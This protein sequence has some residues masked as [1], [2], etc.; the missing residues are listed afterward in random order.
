MNQKEFNQR[1]TMSLLR[2]CAWVWEHCM[3]NQ[4]DG[5]FKFEEVRMGMN[6]NVYDKTPTG[7]IVMYLDW[8]PYWD[9]FDKQDIEGVT[10]DVKSEMARLFILYDRNGDKSLGFGC[11]YRMNDVFNVTHALGVK[12]MLNKAR[13]FQKHGER[14]AILPEVSKPKVKAKKKATTKKAAN[15]TVSLGDAIMAAARAIAA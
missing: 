11:S 13:F 3:R 5:E 8:C 10:Y 14:Y 2:Q 1:I 4:S 15:A 12:A 6:P 7:C 9:I